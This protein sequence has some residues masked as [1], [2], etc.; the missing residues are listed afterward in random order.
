MESWVETACAVV[1]GSRRDSTMRPADVA[2]LA[3]RWQDVI[4][5][6]AQGASDAI[7]RI[8]TGA[9]DDYI[10]RLPHVGGINVR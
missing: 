10:R 3:V 1:N 9:H 4:P 7:T 5:D 2:A 8:T 6:I